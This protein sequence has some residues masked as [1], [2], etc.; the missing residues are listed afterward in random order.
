MV[1]SVIGYLWISQNNEI[2]RMDKQLSQVQQ[3][4]NKY[5][6]YEAMLN[7]MQKQKQVIEKKST[8]IQGLQR[9]RDAVARLLALL[10]IQVPQNRMWFQRLTQAANSVTLEGIAVSNEAIVEFMRNLELSP[11]I[12]KGSVNLTHSRQTLMSNMKLRE[13]QIAYR[14]LTFSEVQKQVKAQGS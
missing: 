10:S 13:F 6:K 14:F 5:A 2:E 12:V 8:V 9:D 11:Y 1:L 3:E 7:E 4:V